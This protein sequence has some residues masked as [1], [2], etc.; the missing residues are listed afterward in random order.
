M[1][2]LKAGTP[3][4]GIRAGH[5][6][7][8]P[9]TGKYTTENSKFW[10]HDHSLPIELHATTKQGKV[11]YE[12]VWNRM[13]AD[14]VSLKLF[15]RNVP[16]TQFHHRY[17][18]LPLT[19]Q[20]QAINSWHKTTPIPLMLE[21]HSNAANTKARGFE[22]FTSPG[23]TKSDKYAEHLYKGIQK[24][25]PQMSLRSD[26]SDGDYDKETRLTMTTKTNCPTILPEFGFFDNAE[27]ILLIMDE[28]IIETYTNLL[29]DTAELAYQDFIS[30]KKMI[31]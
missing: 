3:T 12:G 23:N 16:N 15:A 19:Q 1:N 5:G 27:D 7:I 9:K 30:E 31:K 2:N 6:G 25:I 26:M 17:L 11:F 8:D 22:V 20:Y 4:I 24:N 29:A 28:N 21:L 13:I 10:V 14:K 18:D